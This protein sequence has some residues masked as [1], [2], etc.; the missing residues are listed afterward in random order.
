MQL[1]KYNIL[2]P[3]KEKNR[4]IIINPYHGKYVVV[5]N[6]I[7]EQI[8]NNDLT[9]LIKNDY[10]VKNMIINDVDETLKYNLENRN[11]N[12]FFIFLTFSCNLRCIYCFQRKNKD[13]SVDSQILT[14]KQ[15]DNIFQFIKKNTNEDYAPNVYLFGGEPLLNDATF[16]LIQYINSKSNDIRSNLAIITNGINLTHYHQKIAEMKNITHIQVTVDGP[17]LFIIKEE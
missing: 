9:T 13:Y 17:N 2:F 8:Q 16:Q 1:S 11:R 6:D 10:L 12:D 5:P 4:N 14:E 3:F 7:H 15:V